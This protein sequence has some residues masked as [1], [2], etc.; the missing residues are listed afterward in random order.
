MEWKK[1]LLKILIRTHRTF[2]RLLGASTVGVRI[3]VVNSE[4]EILLVEHTYI[5]G[6][7]L[8]G[9]GVKHM[10]PAAMAAKRELLEETGVIAKDLS[11]HQIYVHNILGVSDYPLLYIVTDFEIQENAK[12]SLEIKQAKWFQRSDLPTDTTESTKIRLAEYF[13]QI[14]KADRW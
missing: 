7:H 3:L 12:P 1:S 8:P 4:R 11:F 14:E 10:E 13:D 5:D 2:Q 6:W 9:G